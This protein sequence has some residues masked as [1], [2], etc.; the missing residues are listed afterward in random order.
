MTVIEKEN[1]FVRMISYKKKRQKIVVDALCV[2]DE[3]YSLIRHLCRETE[4]RDIKFNID[5]YVSIKRADS[6]TT[7]IHRF[8]LEYYALFDNKLKSILDDYTM[9]DNCQRVYK[10]EINHINREKTD[11]RLVNLELVTHQ[12]NTLH[13]YNQPYENEIVM[14]S[15]ELQTIQ[16]RVIEDRQQNI[17]KQFMKRASGKFNK[18]LAEDVV[19]KEIMKYRYLEFNY[20][21]FYYKRQKIIQSQISNC[22]GLGGLPQREKALPKNRTESI[23]E[24]VDQYTEKYIEK[25]LDKYKNKVFNNKINSNINSLNRYQTRHPNIDKILSSFKLNDRTRK[26]L[27]SLKLF[28]NK[29]IYKPKN[30]FILKSKNKKQNSKTLLLDLFDVLRTKSIYTIYD[31]NILATVDIE[32]N[33]STRGKYTAFRVAFLLGL[34]DRQILSKSTRKITGFNGKKQVTS[35]VKKINTPTSFSV[36]IYTEDLLKEANNRAKILLELGLRKINYFNIREVFGE[37][38][39]NSV[40]RNPKCKINYEKYALRTKSDTI[41]FLKK[42]NVINSR[43]YM[44]PKKIVEHLELIND[45]RKNRGEQYCKTFRNLKNFVTS[46]LNDNPEVK[47]QM[48][49]LRYLLH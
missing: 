10:Y 13:R 38:I 36:P 34:I 3:D 28:K 22:S 44:K 45:H 42:N 18:G 23:S 7:F 25:L 15:A 24:N 1:E 33:F 30:K 9:N 14:T 49:E 26:K 27:L 43:G 6:T 47:A 35:K 12:G 29:M 2:I 20:V 17:D 4:Y 40:F 19:Y 37:V 11:N 31:D 48:E 41:N 5:G 46:L 39:A 21:K 32:K 16:K 8:I